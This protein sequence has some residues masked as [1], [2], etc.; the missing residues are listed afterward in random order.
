MNTIA[1]ELTHLYNDLMAQKRK[2]PGYVH[3]SAT[4]SYDKFVLH[5]EYGDDSLLIKACAFNSMAVTIQNS[6]A[7]DYAVR[8]KLYDGKSAHVII[9]G[10][11]IP[12]QPVT[13][14]DRIFILLELPEHTSRPMPKAYTLEIIEPSVAETLMAK[15]L[16]DK[17]ENNSKGITKEK[18][19]SSIRGVPSDTFK[20]ASG[21]MGNGTAW[22]AYVSLHS[23][24]DNPL[25]SRLKVDEQNAKCLA[26]VS[27]NQVIDFKSGSVHTIAV[28]PGE[29]R[30]RAYS[31]ATYTTGEELVSA[32]TIYHVTTKRPEALADEVAANA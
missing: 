15:D 25:A 24:I 3:P 29:N 28:Y 27:F 20:L 10:R 19:L 22:K 1:V 8:G 7:M 4:D 30:S 11:S 17:S 5:L 31:L 9:N 21:D 6:Y 14:G 18:I 16:K 32:S 2:K 23:Y 26:L 13:D 12:F